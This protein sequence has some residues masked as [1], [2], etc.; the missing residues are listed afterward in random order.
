M[1]D[2][3]AALWRNSLQWTG[4]E[5]IVAGEEIGHAAAAHGVDLIPVVALLGA[6]VIAVPLFKRLGLGSV[7]GY[8][9]A[10]LLLGP[11]GFGLISDPESVL[12]IAELGVVMFLF[13]IG[14][15]MEPAKLW[16]LRKQIFGLGVLQV[17]ISG[18][19]LT[20]AG[21]LLGFAP[22][23]AFVFGMGFVLTSTAIVMQVLGERGELA[24]PGGQRMVSILLLEDLAIVPLLALVALLAPTSGE[25]VGVISRLLTVAAPIGAVLLLIFVGRRIMNPFFGVMASSKLREVMT[26]AALL[27]VL[28]AALLFQAVGLSMAMGAFLA[29]VLLSTSS[30][31]HQLE[32]DVE[33]FR[34]ILLGLFFL[35]VGMSLDVAVVMSSW[36]I[37]A[38]SVVAYMVIKGAA[39][40]A[41]ARLLKSSHAEALE[42]AVLMGQG[43]EFAFVLYTTAAA[44]GLIDGPTNAIFTATVIISM[45]LTPCL[46]IGLRYALPKPEQSM[47]GVETVNG[48][49]ERILVIGFGR[50][51][52]IASQ[53]LLGQGH[54]LSIIDND[55]DMIR[56]A[57]QFGFKVYYGDG[58]RL[59]ILRASGAANVDLVLICVDDKS[60]ANHI[61]AMF[62]DEFPLVKVMARAYDRGHAI[63]LVKLGV[64]YQLR[65]LFESAVVF[66]AQAIRAL[67]A[68]EADI[69]TVVQGVRERDA[70]RFKAQL[71]DNVSAVDAAHDLLLRNAA[72]QAREGGIAVDANAVE[73]TVNK[74]T[75][76]AP[77]A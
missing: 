49:A 1:L 69:E 57:A 21:V 35:A 11:S 32:A 4:G 50:F 14:L 62:R 76:P 6:A 73:D 51:G 65:E 72:E 70:L 25:E 46:M 41:I 68:S 60:A 7:L 5:I 67:G 77:P 22:M 16:A 30:F 47:E 45:V 52:Q 29:G 18:A 64:D 23:V 36:Q 26:A 10:G 56:V 8:L 75:H 61:A 37:I 24:S 44:A 9:A 58:T 59:D 43:G 66:G 40:Y 20:G 3:T 17:A 53:T 74:I 71:F 63:E 2:V 39:I 55:T 54:N 28:G 33:P 15:E 12:T 19:L 34:G 48:L 13:I 38:L 31:R 27:V 42:R